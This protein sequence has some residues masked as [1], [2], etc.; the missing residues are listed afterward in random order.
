VEDAYIPDPYVV[1]LEERL[2]T[3]L[4][5]LARRHIGSVLVTRCGKLAGIFTATDAC[6][7]FASYLRERLHA[8]EGD[9][10]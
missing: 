7:L 5:E 6:E 2:D 1:D 3:V 8:G 10:A 4:A 9:T